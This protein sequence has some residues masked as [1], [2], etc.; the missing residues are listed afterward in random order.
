MWYSRM[1]F[2]A[3]FG[4]KNIIKLCKYYNFIG[5]FNHIYYTTKNGKSQSFYH[6]FLCLF[7]LK[8]LCLK[9]Y[10]N[11]NFFIYF[12]PISRFIYLLNQNLLVFPLVHY[13]YLPP[14]I[15]GR[16]LV[17]YN[18]LFLFARLHLL[19]YK[20]QTLYVHHYLDFHSNLCQ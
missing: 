10:R 20:M 12:W 9:H 17:L 8:V 19:Y 16:L 5:F 4:R 1:S 7:S 11:I 3:V 2:R 14:Y 18:H 13:H 6:Y 15:F